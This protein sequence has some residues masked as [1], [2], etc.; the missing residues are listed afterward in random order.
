MALSQQFIQLYYKS[1]LPGVC[2]EQCVKQYSKQ[3]FYQ[4]KYILL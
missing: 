1:R 2:H 3:S 4:I